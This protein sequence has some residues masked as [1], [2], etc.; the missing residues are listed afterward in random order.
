MN[1]AKIMITLLILIISSSSALAEMTKK[2]D[3]GGGS[4]VGNGFVAESM[5]V[6]D[7]KIKCSD[8]KAMVGKA[9][10]DAKTFQL[11][12]D[13]KF[14]NDKSDMDLK[15]GTFVVVNQK[16]IVGIVKK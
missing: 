11:S 8:L 6:K 16:G 2:L 14:K 9:T 15:S 3:G 5:A 1:L 12:D 7:A 10:K 4:A 13:C